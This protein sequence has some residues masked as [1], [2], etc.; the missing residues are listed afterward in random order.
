MDEFLKREMELLPAGI[1]KTLFRL[2]EKELRLLQNE[3]NSLTAD[4]AI[5]I[6]ANLRAV[7]NTAKEIR[8][9]LE[10][11]ASDVKQASKQV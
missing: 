8:R 6:C 4:K 9:D 11:V 5:S 1:K 2:L 10:Q 3:E 7:L